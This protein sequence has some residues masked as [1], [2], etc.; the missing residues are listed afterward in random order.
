VQK[1]VEHTEDSELPLQQAVKETS[2]EVPLDMRL[3]SEA[4]I[5]LNI[6]RK[7]VGIYPPGHIQITKSIDRAFTL[8]QKLFEIR[9]EMTLGVAKD[10]LLVGQD[11]LDRKNPVFRD[12][13]LSMNQQG[14]AAVTFISGL[15][16][17]QLVRF[18]QI[19]TTKPEDVMSMGGIDTV[20][21]NVAIPNIRV[22]AIDYSS[23]HLTEESEI[24]RPQNNPL[25][26]RSRE[27]DG[28][29]AAGGNAG[30]GIWQSFVSHLAAGTLAGQGQAGVSL[31]DAEQIDPAELAKLLNERKL[32]PGL[33]VQ[34]YDQTI[35]SYIRGAAAKKLTTEQSATL[36]SLNKLIKDLSPELRKQFLS[37]A[38]NRLSVDTQSPAAEDVVGGLTDDMVIEML[39]Q[40]SAEGKQ[41]S[42]SLAGLVQRLSTLRPASKL[43]GLQ[44]GQKRG[45]VEV[46][47]S[48]SMLPGNMQ[49]L[50]NREDH[51]QHVSTEY[52]DLLK[53]VT[54]GGGPAV[55]DFPI[56]EY[57]LTLE[58]D[59]LDYQ[60]G[61]A[62][63]AFMEER[64]DA[65]DY[66]E[67]AS[68]LVTILP[69]F[70]GTGNFELLWDISETLRRHG[71]DKPSLDTRQCAKESLQ[72]F[73]DPEFI[74]K[75]L[76]AFELWMQDKGQE[77][78]G[79]IQALGIGT[80]PGLMDIYSKDESPGGKR[81]VFNLLS[82]F[83][84]SA[85]REAQK[86]LGDAKPNFTRNLL[87]LIRRTGSPESI[88]Y[89][90][91]L[92][93]HPDQTVRMEALS[94]MLK[95]KGPGAIPALREALNSQDA[96]V[97][98][99]AVIL[100]GLYRVQEVT[101]AVL[102]RLKRVILF[103]AD[104]TY[105]EEIIRALG[106]IGDPRAIPELEKLAQ[107]GWSLYAKRQMKMKEFL[108]ESLGRYPRKSVS[109]LLIIGSLMDNE[110]IKSSCRKIAEGE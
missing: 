27:K 60:I 22:Q 12:F 20:M 48:P 69:Q 52:D 11:Y 41:I 54:E 83:G 87:M 43:S 91:P 45:K 65:E 47:S 37:V 39:G 92:L 72:L 17:E 18:H 78:A 58:D 61:R 76:A 56:E 33:A 86:R 34:S 44:V 1:P 106:E 103:E 79:F 57:L 73:A 26:R 108:F 63:L 28:L 14:I 82:Q 104:Y 97:S 53:K 101:P 75:V 40:A 93:R 100:A 10:T 16:R 3:L 35:S 23:L 84:E 98:S 24:A 55:E 21:R 107:A 19:I 109:G 80:I 7:N 81:I 6:S 66:R 15:D 50:F 67:F 88:P 49:A 95:F 38:F 71:M 62:L 77:G 5:E 36:A 25:D 51:E 96:D 32:D 94:T 64:I 99:Q 70:L 4:I 31:K 8:L 89:V 29:N 30:T 90:E 59:R 46:L 102:A 74:T 42:P 13:A 9:T 85:A 110:S 2:R 105:N 68:K